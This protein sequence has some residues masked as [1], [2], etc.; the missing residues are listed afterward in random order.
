[1]APVDKREVLEKIREALRR[2]RATL[3][4]SARSAREGAT[5]EEAK[6]EDDKDTRALE[7][8]YLA[9]AQAGRLRALE[10]MVQSLEFFELRE[11]RPQDPIA[12][13]AVVEVEDEDGKKA[14][15]FLAAVA[16]GTKIKAGGADIQV[17]TGES[18]LGQLLVGRKQGESF[19]RSV[20]GETREY[21]IVAV[22]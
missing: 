19:E 15:Y 5:H 7:A 1:M 11:F 16:G 8:S 22:R 18:P 3:E 13:S 17:I 14:T 20:K 4:Q 10:T 6:P 9:G 2:E 12:L 21:E